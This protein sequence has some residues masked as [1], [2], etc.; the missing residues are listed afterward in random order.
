MIVW[1]L[2]M[3]VNK[4]WKSKLWTTYYF[5]DFVFDD[6]QVGMLVCD[7]SLAAMESNH[8]AY[9][10][11]YV[12]LFKHLYVIGVWLAKDQITN[13]IKKTHV[14]K[15][16]QFF[17]I[18]H[19]LTPHSIMNTVWRTYSPFIW[20]INKRTLPITLYKGRSDFQY[21]TC[22]CFIDSLLMQHKFEDVVLINI[23]WR[24]R[25]MHQIPWTTLNETNRMLIIFC[26]LLCDEMTCLSYH[27]Q[28]KSLIELHCFVLLMSVT[29]WNYA[30]P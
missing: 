14:Q 10:C 25:T 17:S 15:R 6:W 24:I 19:E 5:R 12:F 20:R 21:G 9:G 22:Q 27:N 7:S 3:V 11:Y 13:T 18:F 1:K 16:F 8:K 26:K 2:I 30:L 29:I 28:G 4:L 23:W